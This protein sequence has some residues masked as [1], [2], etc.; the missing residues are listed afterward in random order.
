[1][2]Y[3]DKLLPKYGRLTTIREYI[4]RIGNHSHHFVDCVCD[5]GKELKLDYQRLKSGNTKSCGC[6]KKDLM[7]SKATHGLTNSKEY[8]S[9]RAMKSRCYSETNQDYHLYGGRG[10]VVCDRWLGEDGFSNFIKDMGERPEKHSL[11]RIDSN[12]NY[13]PENCRWSTQKEQCRNL[14]RNKVIIYKDT[15][16]VMSELCEKFNLDYSMFSRRLYRGWEVEDAVEAPPGIR[17][18]TYLKN[19]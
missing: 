9:Y 18:E 8:I 2:A 1:M 11:D 5:C 16:Y 10:I 6:Y 17:Y 15:D 19:K 14:S 3:K 7:K 4:E 13:S 12:G